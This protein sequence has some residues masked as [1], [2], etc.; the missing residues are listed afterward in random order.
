MGYDQLAARYERVF[1]PQV[2]FTCTF[3]NKTSKPFLVGIQIAGKAGN[4]TFDPSTFLERPRTRYKYLTGNGSSGGKQT[5]T[6]TFSLKK[7]LGALKWDIKDFS[8]VINADPTNLVYAYISVMQLDGQAMLLN[9]VQC[10]VQMTMKCVFME[11]T[12]IAQSTI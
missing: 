3:N 4:Q 8:H 10:S 6:Y 11:P 1:V 12:T 9:D 7:F 2:K 5:V